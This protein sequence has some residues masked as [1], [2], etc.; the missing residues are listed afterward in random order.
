MG[1]G[2][3]LEPGQA[4]QCL[5]TNL[6]TV[7]EPT[8]DRYGP[9]WPMSWLLNGWLTPRFCL[10]VVLEASNS[11]AYII[12]SSVVSCRLNKQKYQPR[13][14]ASFRPLFYNHIRQW[15]VVAA[16]ILVDKKGRAAAQRSLRIKLH[17]H[18]SPISGSREPKGR[19]TGWT[20]SRRWRNLTAQPSALAARKPGELEKRPPNSKLRIYTRRRFA[21]IISILL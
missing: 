13:D 1:A 11:Y 5:V 19:A 16:H 7:S 18:T 20:Q 3:G 10:V 14:T 15:G 4:P 8:Y 17:T 9:Y 6:N 12:T 21:I 2:G